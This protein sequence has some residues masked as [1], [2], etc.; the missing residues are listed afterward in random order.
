L[1]RYLD[2]AHRVLACAA[3]G[4]VHVL[5]EHVRRQPPKRL[6]VLRTHSGVCGGSDEDGLVRRGERRRGEERR[7][8]GKL[9]YWFLRVQEEADGEDSKAAFSTRQPVGAATVDCSA[10]LLATAGKD[11]DLEVK[12][13]QP[14]A[15]KS[16]D[17]D[18]ASRVAQAAA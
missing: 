12:T 11:N 2:G 5:D 17:C 3:D 8:E 9:G 13:H 16:C 6:T 10:T 15:C 18:H 7:R 1:V 14:A 4:G